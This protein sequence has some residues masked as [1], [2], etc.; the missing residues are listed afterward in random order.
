MKAYGGMAVPEKQ[1]PYIHVRHSQFAPG[2]ENKNR[3]SNLGRPSRCLATI[4]LE[5]LSTLYTFNF[6]DHFATAKHVCAQ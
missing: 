3:E 2:D 1:L 5:L 4:L 6:E